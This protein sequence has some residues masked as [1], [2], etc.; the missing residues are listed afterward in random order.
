MI[1]FLLLSVG[2]A[3]N[4]DF[5]HTLLPASDPLF[6]AAKLI[7]QN[8]TDL[9]TCNAKATSEA[10]CGVTHPLA[11]CTGS[12]SGLN[13]VS[14]AAWQDLAKSTNI[15]GWTHCSGALLDPCSCNTQY[16]GVTCADGDI[17]QMYYCTT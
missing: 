11:T 15:T 2:A 7:C 13:A 8:C 9:S 3:T 12:S 6:P 10:K 1:S 14:C 17:T 16:G 5:C 4:P